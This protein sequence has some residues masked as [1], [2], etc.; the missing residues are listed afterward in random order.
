MACSQIPYTTEQG[1]SKCISGKVSPTNSEI[2]VRRL[3]R[4]LPSLRTFTQHARP[5]DATQLVRN[6]VRWPATETTFSSYAEIG[7]NLL[8]RG[9][10][11]ARAG[12]AIG[13]M[14]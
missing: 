10:S 1:S 13:T 9:K 4:P 14:H 2:I 12:E 8:R 6:R 7:H 5:R 3:R 11:T